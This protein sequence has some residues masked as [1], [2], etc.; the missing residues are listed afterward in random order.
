MPTSL[1]EYDDRP[2][3]KLLPSRVTLFASR[4]E[5][6]GSNRM[7]WFLLNI[8]LFF[9][10]GLCALLGILFFGNQLG[11]FTR[12][13]PLA[14]Y[15]TLLYFMFLADSEAVFIELHVELFVDAMDLMKNC[16]PTRPLGPFDGKVAACAKLQGET[17]FITTNQ[18]YVPALPS[19]ELPH[20]V[21]LRSDMRYGTDD[22]TIWPQ[23]YTACFCHLPV[24]AKKGAR[25]DLDVMWWDPATDDF[26]VGSAV[27]RALGRVHNRR[28]QE[29]LPFVN[30]MVERC[31]ELKHKSSAPIFPLF[32]ELIQTIIALIEQ[33]QTFPTTYP[34]MV[35]AVTSLQRACLELD[36]LYFYFTTFKPR[37][38][39][40]LSS[41]PDH[42]YSDSNSV[43][44]CIGA[45]TVDPR[46]A[47][48]LW[49]ARLPFWFL[50][51]T[52][53]FDP[54]NILSIVELDHD[55]RAGPALLFFQ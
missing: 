22:P 33:L 42:P 8:T 47:Q 23:Q 11:I 43:A 20:T 40:Y 12:K 45:F 21:F 30:E 31:Q 14:L 44:K 16:D 3:G 1:V 13:S 6:V 17:Y 53:V 18:D 26:I 36:A 28:V 34:K 4:P 49:S 25:S 41:P 51:P 32:G 29:F 37:I 9:L 39:K 50:R 48:Q 38:D 55:D 27:T 10:P 24:I 15:Y 46:V 35:F 52:Y 2:S 5:A 54:E 7:R 19:L